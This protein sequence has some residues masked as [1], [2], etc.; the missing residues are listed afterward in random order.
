MYPKQ[1]RDSSVIYPKQTRDSSVMY[2]KHDRISKHKITVCGISILSSN[3]PNEILSPSTL[4]SIAEADLIVTSSNKSKIIEPFLNTRTRVV[5]MGSKG[6]SLT[7][8]VE[9]I[10][11][12]PGKTVVV[13]SGDPGFYGIVRVLADAFGPDALEVKPSPSS[14]SVAF[15][16]LGIPWDDAL[17]ISAHGR[18]ASALPTL[19]SRYNKV[20]LLSSPDLD[21]DI[22]AHSPNS[23]DVSVFLFECLGSTLERVRQISLNALG[24]FRD[25]HEPAVLILLRKPFISPDPTIVWPPS[26]TRIAWGLPTDLYDRSNNQ[27]TKP[28]VRSVVLSKLNLAPNGHLWDLGAG[29]GSVG[30]E[31]NLIFPLLRVTCVE[32]DPTK[33]ELIRKNAGQHGVEVNVINSDIREAIASLQF[34]DSIFVGGGGLEILDRVLELEGPAPSIVAT[35]SAIDRAIYAHSKLGNMCEINVSQ[36]SSLADGGIRLSAQNPVFV[37]WNSQGHSSSYF[38]VRSG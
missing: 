8:S 12:E 6:V 5:T 32:R 28:E 7:Q 25:R 24:S 33:C 36:A 10:F 38:E 21:F 1:A 14:I 23:Q 35:Y 20:A 13:A 16:R 18:N 30:I 37:V 34:A 22:L 17:V 26:P 4:R 15:A 3:H 31:A 11:Q 27:I 9:Q 2:P 19:V 29:S